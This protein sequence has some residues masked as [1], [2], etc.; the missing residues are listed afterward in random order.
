MNSSL[1]SYEESMSTFKFLSMITGK[2]STGVNV[3]EANMIGLLKQ[4][5]SNLRLMMSKQGSRQHVK[6]INYDHDKIT[7]IMRGI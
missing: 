5:V 3:N 1:N 4:E 6:Q 7:Q 2:K